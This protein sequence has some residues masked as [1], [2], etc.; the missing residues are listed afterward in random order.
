MTPVDQPDQ[1]APAY[2]RRSSR[3]A[4][5]SNPGEGRIAI[6]VGQS[7]SP[8]A[9]HGQSAIGDDRERDL[10]APRLGK[11]GFSDGRTIADRYAN[12]QT[13]PLGGWSVWFAGLLAIVAGAVGLYSVVVLPGSET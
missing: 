11:L 12:A 1:V 4:L 9:G 7:A 5:L 10:P 13:G 6:S 3:P 8:Q 2:P